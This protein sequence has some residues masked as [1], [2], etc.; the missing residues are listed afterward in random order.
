MLGVQLNYIVIRLLHDIFIFRIL[1]MV[2]LSISVV[3]VV[4]TDIIRCSDFCEDFKKSFSYF[5]KLIDLLMRIKF[6]FNEKLF[7]YLLFN[8]KHENKYPLGGSVEWLSK[9]EMS[10]HEPLQCSISHES[11]NE[12]R[13]EAE[14]NTN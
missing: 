9:M 8:A 1:L 5:I 14:Q 13:K 4:I 7:L 11:R 3:V 2:V 10:K 12:R 6:L